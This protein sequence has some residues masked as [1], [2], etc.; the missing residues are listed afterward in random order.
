MEK[1]LLNIRTNTKLI[2]IVQ[3]IVFI[4]VILYVLMFLSGGLFTTFFIMLIACF[5]SVIAALLMLIRKSFLWAIVDLAAAG[6]MFIY[7]IYND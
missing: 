6:G 5:V 3:T 2:S 4:F 7:F 1:I